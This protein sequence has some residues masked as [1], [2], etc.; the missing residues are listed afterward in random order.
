MKIKKD[1][2]S[3]INREGL[4]LVFPIKNDK[5]PH[6]IWNELYPKSKMRW[7]WDVTGD[8][9]VVKLWQLKT[10]LSVTKE[11]VYTKW[12][13]NRAT[14]FSKELFQACLRLEMENPKTLSRDSKNLLDTL[15]S[16]SPL[17]TKQLKALTELQGKMFESTYNKSM[18]PLWDHFQI[19]AFGEFEDSS[20]PSLGIGATQTLFEDLF[21]AARDLSLKKALGLVDEKMPKGSKFRKYFDKVMD[22]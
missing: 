19:V 13:Q 2:I 18:R 21:L 4:M 20:F 10:D 3:A 17:S 7:D 22:I 1:I 15:I 16:D 9:R 12:Y 8:D 5:E 11:V 6:S 14:Y